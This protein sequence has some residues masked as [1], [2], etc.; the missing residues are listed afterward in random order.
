MTLYLALG[1]LLLVIAVIAVNS[2]RRA[3]AP[4]KPAPAIPRHTE[5]PRHDGPAQP[6]PATITREIPAALATLQ[7]TRLSDLAPAQVEALA[8][9]LQKIPRPPHAMDKLVSAEFLAN[10]SSAELSDL[11]V[12]EPQITAKVLATV[13]SSAYG[14]QKPLGSIGQAATYLG[15]NT[16]R[17]ICLQY[18][19][20]ASFKSTSPE[21]KAVYESIW[22][23]SAFSSELCFKLAQLLKLPEP[24]NLV[25][26][27]VLSYLGPLAAYS[28]LDNASVL[29]LSH[30]TPVE[31]ARA[32]QAA[33][34]LCGTE[35][36][37][38]L[39]QTWKVPPSLIADA[40]VIAQ[41]MVEPCPTPGD[42]RCARL[43]L[44]YLCTQIGA[45]LAAGSILHVQTLDIASSDRIELHFLPSYLEH[46]SFAR[47]G[48]FLKMPEI[49]SL[50]KQMKTSTH[51]RVAAPA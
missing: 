6:R 1:L 7:L 33:L 32:E 19:L 12:G 23:A 2:K 16:V 24:G 3:S 20:D 13:N 10:A 35:I 40:S 27:V 28:L 30:Y 45:A 46:P 5:M 41:T 51:L 43:A 14:L 37:K 18:M 4:A 9:R 17:G 15:M 34:G 8:A 44:C 21:V 50:A 31:R 11:M 22:S 48:D 25:T 26:Q 36:A 29:R 47:L 49:V 42:A 38:L 39:L